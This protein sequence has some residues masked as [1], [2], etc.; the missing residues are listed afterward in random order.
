MKIGINGYEAVV[1]RFGYD[2]S[3]LPVRVGSAEFCYQ[4]LNGIS[5][6]KINSYTIFLPVNPSK[7]LPASSENWKYKVFN[8]KLWT[9]LQL[10]KKLINSNE[11]LDIFF[12]P[13]HY[14]PVVTKAPSI[15]SILDVS[16]LKFPHLFKKKDLLMLKYWGRFSISKARKIITISESSKNDIINLYKVSPQKIAV[17]YPGIEAEKTKTMI[18]SNLSE[19]FGISKEF[20]LYV[21]TLQPRKNVK[22]LIEAFSKIENK[23]VELVLIGKKGWM[24]EDIISAPEKYDVKDRVKFFHDVSDEDLPSF[25]SNCKFFVL[26]SLYEGFGL[27]VLEAMKYDAPVITSN[28]SS[29]PEA[30]GDAALYV[31]PENVDDIVLKMNK[32]DKDENLRDSL[33]KKGK[34][35]VKKFSWEKAAKETIKIFEE[36]ANVSKN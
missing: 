35:Q 15:I 1:P 27:P 36:V 30:G 16:Y 34:D 13:T 28:V 32:L 6:D 23:E 18:A 9:L 8:G 17:I 3:G 11:K 19:K 22:R 20:I 21:G 5:L 24:Y 29:L 31:D 10:S 2:K 33:R 25:Y 12:S 14:S 7:D 4:L 26:A